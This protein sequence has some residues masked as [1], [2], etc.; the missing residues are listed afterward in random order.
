MAA[1]FSSY[2]KRLRRK[3]F[4]I[5]RLIFDTAKATKGVGAIEETM[6]WGQVS[7]LT[8]E[9]KS[10]STIRIDGVKSAPDQYALYFHC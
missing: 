5:R 2:P 8:R 3:L 7:Y 6:K 9:S 1:A 4:A 10:G